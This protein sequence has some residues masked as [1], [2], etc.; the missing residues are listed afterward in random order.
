MR[1]PG[2]LRARI[3]VAAVAAVA[4]CGVV[5]GVILLAAVESDGR[6]AVDDDLRERATEILRRP[7]KEGFGHER[8]GP[9]PGRLGAGSGAFA[10]VAYRDEVVEQ[11]GDVPV[12]APGVPEEDGLATVEIKGES[13]R[14]LTTTVG[15][16]GETRLQVLSSLAGVEERVA[17][18]RRLVLLLGLVALALTALAAWGFT[19]VAVRPLGRLREGAARVSGAEDLST[20]LPED[21]GPDEVRALAGTLNEML[22]RLQTST[23]AT[24]RALQATRRFAADAGHELRT[25]LTALRADLDAIERNPELSPEQRR[26]LLRDA[27]GEQQR[28]VH[29]LEGLQALARG[30]AAETLPREP[31][32]L[33]DV[34]DAAVFAARRRHPA[35]AYQ[36]DAQLDE[37]RVEGWEGGLRLLID[38]LLDNAAL[39][40]RP[41]DGRV[42]IGLAREDG[43]VLLRVEDNGAG[44][45]PGD[46]AR[47]L[48]P[49]ARGQDA[50]APGT[51]LGLAIVAQQ[52]ALHG[53]ELR[54]DQS[55]LGGLGVLVR[56][57]AR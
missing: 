37:G 19:T 33:G 35:V 39:H 9:P 4:L 25:P 27:L 31:V 2:S 24:E 7:G 5:T 26:A 20:R 13:W 1:L 40:G 12:A 32:E 52:A 15:V 42:R 44:I 22:A 30:E 28:M 45:P 56:L 48:E 34:V 43:A 11:E 36:L 55:S 16:S 51:G 18:I 54:L 8:R 6:A 46:R 23:E 38:N 50:T 53:G 49:F 3:A 14:S 29:L 10:Q 41:A 57:P 21:E 17:D 47:L